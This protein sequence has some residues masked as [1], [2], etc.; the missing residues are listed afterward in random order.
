MHSRWRDKLLQNGFTIIELIVVIS[1]IAILATVSVI[2]YS[3][4]RNST[5]A[6]KVKSDLNAAGSALEDYRTFNNGYPATTTLPS[7][8]TPSNGVNLSLYSSDATA[9]CVDG[10]STEI[11]SITYYLAA[12]TKDQGPKSGTCATRPGQ[13]V[14]SVPTGIAITSK[15]A[16]SISLSWS[17]STNSPTSYTVQCASDA[18]F[19]VGMKQ[20]TQATT[21]TTVSGLDAA[22]THYCRVSARNGAGTS[23]WSG[24]I[25]SNTNSYLC[26]DL[27]K[28]GT[29]PDCYDYDALPI[30]TSI[31]G[32]WTDAP[33][34]F[35]IE[36]GSA[37]SRTTYSDLFAAIGTTYGDGD[38][39]TTFNLP[40]S[41]GR[42]VVGR[43][44]TDSDFNSVGEKTGAK[45]DV[46]TIAELP[47]H[48]HIQNAHS[49]YFDVHTS[50]AEAGG[51][52]LHSS[53]SFQNRVYVNSGNGTY[54]AT[55][56]NQTT[57]GSEAHNIV[58]PSIVKSFAIKYRPSTGTD[59]L[60]PA[61]TSIK[62]YWS[63]A[64][65]GYL[66][67][68]GTEVSRTTYSD[69]FAVIGTT[70]G[71]GDGSTTF[72]LPDERGRVSVN[73]SSTDSEFNS[74]GEKY[75]E[76]AHIMTIAELPAHTH[77][78]NAHNHGFYSYVSSSEAAG[79]GVSGGGG[80]VNAVIVNG[81]GL[82]TSN[83]TATNQST[84]SD[85]AETVIQPSI[86]Q[87]IAIKYTNP[88]ATG[89]SVAT[90]TSLSGY[91]PSVPSGYLAE[92]GSAVSRTTY[93]DLFAKIGTTYGAGNGSTTFNLPDSRGRVGVNL[94]PSDSEFDTMGEKYG[95]KT[96]LMT[97]A[98]MAEHTHI[99]NA[100]SHS[101]G[102]A[103]AGGGYGACGCSAFRNRL[104]VTGGGIGSSS[105]TATNQS[106][107]GGQA[108]NIIQPSL[109]K[110][111]VIKF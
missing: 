111:F 27:D 76:K 36:D 75:G 93:A 56:T 21:A 18:G 54:S 42:T 7:T 46:Q 55:A 33:D 61:G 15:T 39:S 58:Q 95:E 50:G 102:M 77:I 66:L 49:H 6:T 43:D 1:I 8:V 80:W 14:P 94:S 109:V 23:A 92:D 45:T 2:G 89:S 29:Y 110:L 13:S 25:S 103:A 88:T 79:Y 24:A 53:G 101:F 57:G 106:E 38:G 104:M 83:A 44:S 30:A 85:E 5:I 91:W 81:Y 12:E 28:Y 26:S 78:Q 87:K 99:Q 73:K 60:L 22:T 40:D 59:S 63:S 67:E 86:V 19:I 51:Y 11:T 37:I 35:L 9:F 20:S 41:R 70:Y 17:A 74:M 100:H 84:G 68:Y 32:Y 64:P 96:H 97:L 82:G 69:L 10:A 48:T 107:G 105:T 108:F 72:N 65:S 31:E 4:W 34:G 16:T 52:G 90:G 3:S 62:G 47:S 71:D 98:E